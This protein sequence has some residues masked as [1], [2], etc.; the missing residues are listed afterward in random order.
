MWIWGELWKPITKYIY[1]EQI[2]IRKNQAI[3]AAENILNKYNIQYDIISYELNRYSE[4]FEYNI[5]IYSWKNV[6]K[7]NKILL[8]KMSQFDNDM[9]RIPYKFPKN[10]LSTDSCLHKRESNGDINIDYCTSDLINNWQQ[11]LDKK[12]EQNKNITQ[13]TSIW[14]EILVLM[15]KQKS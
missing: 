1:D 15:I 14:A 10:N 11:P 4:V 12:Q 6:Y 9:Y 7:Y 13:F 3:V 5:H 2:N 8:S